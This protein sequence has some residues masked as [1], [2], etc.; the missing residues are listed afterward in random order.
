MK[1]LAIYCDEFSYK[2][3]K[4][5]LE[6]VEDISDFEEFKDVQLAFIQ[7]EMHDEEN[8][9]SI[10]KKLLN[11]LKWVARNNST[12]KILLH[13]FAH[14]SESKASAEFTKQLLDNV[15]KRLKNVDYI[16]SQTPFGYFLDLNLSAPGFSMAR[17]FKSF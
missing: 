17:V 13:S 1:I 4:K 9:K 12:K 14:L 2:P 10:E 7:A 16:A 6:S 3:G 15:E 5:N 8:A 11:F